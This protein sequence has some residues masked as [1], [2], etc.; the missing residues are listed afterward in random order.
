ME[1]SPKK[2]KSAD[3]GLHFQKD[4]VIPDECGDSLWE[5]VLEQDKVKALP[6][7]TNDEDKGI[8]NDGNSEKGSNPNNM[9]IVP[10]ANQ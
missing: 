7:D 9:P 4:T 3:A 6:T 5:A 10:N 8:L 1:L 2:E